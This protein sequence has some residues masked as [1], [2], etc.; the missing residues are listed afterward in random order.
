M[1][2][3]KDISYHVD[4][5]FQPI[6]GFSLSSGWNPYH[7]IRP[8][9]TF[10]TFP[11]VSL[12]PL[13]STLRLHFLCF[14]NAWCFF[15][16]LGLWPCYSLCPNC[17]PL[18]PAPFPWPT[19]TQPSCLTLYQVDLPL[20]PYGNIITLV[21]SVEERA[22]S[23]SVLCPLKLVQHSA[24]SRCSI[25][26]CYM[27]WNWK[28]WEGK[29]HFTPHPC[30]PQSMCFILSFHQYPEALQPWKRKLGVPK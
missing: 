1:L 10:P 18:T 24:Q 22:L 19:P 6:N 29:T 15:L 2:I 17:S 3:Y 28:K 23:F 16:V 25:I 12:P 8:L 27:A 11:H 5:S 14:P 13:I 26:V 30:L 9:P 4:S 21:S 20:S 7:F